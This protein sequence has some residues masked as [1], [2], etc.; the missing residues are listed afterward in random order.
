MILKDLLEESGQ[1]VDIASFA[2]ASA[3]CQV[4]VDPLVG[5]LVSTPAP[6]EKAE[7]SKPARKGK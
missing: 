3:L 1:T 6:T 2:A 4:P 7:P 5:P